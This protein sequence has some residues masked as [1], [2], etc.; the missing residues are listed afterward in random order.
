MISAGS[1]AVLKKIIFYM[2]L[3][4]QVRVYGCTELITKSLM[5]TFRTLFANLT[6]SKRC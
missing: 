5:F 3:N 2:R 4:I 1:T 6:L